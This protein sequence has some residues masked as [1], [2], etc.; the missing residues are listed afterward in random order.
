MFDKEKA[1]KYFIIAWKKR[2]SLRTYY[3][4]VMGSKDAH[5]DSANENFPWLPKD[6]FIFL[7]GETVPVYIAKQFPKLNELLYSSKVESLL[8]LHKIVMKS[9]SRNI[10]FSKDKE[11]EGVKKEFINER[12][13]ASIFAGSTDIDKRKRTCWSHVK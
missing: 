8:D 12:K 4:A 1:A 7:R 3:E 2:W 10:R 9:K 13:T 11:F 5:F 6:K